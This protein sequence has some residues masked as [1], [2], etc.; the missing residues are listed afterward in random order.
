MLAGGATLNI[1]ANARIKELLAPS[2]SLLLP[3]C[4]D[5]TGQSLG[6]L[7]YYCHEREHLPVTCDMPFL[8]YSDAIGDA[9]LDASH[10]RDELVSFLVAGGIVFLHRGQSEIGP[11]ALGHRS[12]L[13]RPTR[14]NFDLINHVIKQREF[15]RPLAPLVPSESVS[16]WFAWEGESKYMLYAAGVSERAQLQAPGICHY[17]NSAR[18]QTID[19]REDAFLHQVLSRVEQATGCPILINTS[20]N[21]RGAPI[22]SKLEAT[23][24]FAASL[25]GLGVRVFHGGS[26]LPL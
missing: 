14:K 24:T 17:D 12:I 9:K 10:V 26:L 23:L 5:D 20:L 1:V 7:L 19:A 18:V 11:R 2:R 6:A 25:K 3:P 8:G 22:L 4:C 16:D 13:A 21:P 15:Y